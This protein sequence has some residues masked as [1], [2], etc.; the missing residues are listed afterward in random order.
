MPRDFKVRPTVNGA[1]IATEIAV[2][3]FYV[4][5]TVSTGTGTARFRVRGSWTIVEVNASVNTA[6]TGSSL[7]VDVNKNG[8]TVFT[9]QSNRPTIAISGF[10]AAA[11]AVNVT[12]IVD[13]DYLTL[14]VDQVGSTIAGSDL[15]V[16]VWARP[17]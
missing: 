12:S 10:S 7:I 4:P 11:A 2:V 6:P 15:T 9:T 14:D 3:T 16:E 5:S 8:T 13:A 1:G 17:T